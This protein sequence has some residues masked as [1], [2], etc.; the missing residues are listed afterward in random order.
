MRRLARVNTARSTRNDTLLTRDVVNA[1]QLCAS[2]CPDPWRDGIRDTM[3]S[4]YSNLGYTGSIPDQPV[5]RDTASSA[6]VPRDADE[7]P[8]KH[9]QIEML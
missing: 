2:Q 6:P 8:R 3:G 5:A 4:I 9:P 1:L 7:A